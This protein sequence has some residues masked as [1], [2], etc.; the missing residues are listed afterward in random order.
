MQHHDDHAD[1]STS[2]AALLRT[3]AA[4]TAVSAELDARQRAWQDRALMGALRA[5]RAVQHYDDAMAAREEAG[6]LSLAMAPQ[7]LRRAG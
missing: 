7:R 5:G 6:G 4:G 1:L 3:A 2:I